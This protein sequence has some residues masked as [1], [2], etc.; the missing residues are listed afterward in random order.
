MQLHCQSNKPT[1]SAFRVFACPM[2]CPA[3][4][5]RMIAPV[6]SE[7][8]DGGEIRHH[9][10]CDACGEITSTVITLERL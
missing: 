2:L 1:L 8:A 9:W 7:F 5:D 4:G 10:K 3:C 6:S